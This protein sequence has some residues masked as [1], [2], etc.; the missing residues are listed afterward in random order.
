MS[1]N[2]ALVRISGTM[3][4]MYLSNNNM[5]LLSVI[6]FTNDTLAL[7]AVSYRL[8][9]GAVA[10]QGWRPRISSIVTG[11]G[12]YSLSRSLMV[13]EQMYYA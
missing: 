6:V 13:S 10:E 3:Y 7:L 5:L 9:T 1:D 8:A 12:L 2:F 11:K 4:C